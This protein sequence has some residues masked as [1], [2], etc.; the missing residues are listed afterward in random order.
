M[1]V[2]AQYRS[3]LVGFSEAIDVLFGFGICALIALVVLA[4]ARLFI[5]ENLKKRGQ[6]ST[7]RA[8]DLAEEENKIES[9]INKIRN[10]IAELA[11]TCVASPGENASSSRP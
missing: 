6:A 1:Y 8:C 2:I 10:T 9:E 11:K 7:A 5:D 3:G 4:Y